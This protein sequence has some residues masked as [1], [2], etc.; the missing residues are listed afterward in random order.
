M[1]WPRG[2]FYIV[3]L[4]LLCMRKYFGE[5]KINPYNYFD[6]SNMKNKESIESYVVNEQNFKI[7][8]KTCGKMCRPDSYSLV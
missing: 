2:F 8:I 4:I 3:F 5:Q 7:N 6:V 1:C